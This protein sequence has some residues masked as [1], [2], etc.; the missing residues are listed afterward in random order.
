M[1]DS[2]ANDGLLCTGLRARRS[3][4]IGYESQ[5]PQTMYPTDTCSNLRPKLYII[6][7]LHKYSC[8][9]VKYL[10][11]PTSVFKQG[12]VHTHAD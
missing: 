3:C 12:V 4:K 1:T 5:L 2:I 11:S 6:F 7:C 10:S 9:I 8:D